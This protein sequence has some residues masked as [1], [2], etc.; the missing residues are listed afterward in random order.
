MWPWEHVAV[1]YIAYSLLSRTAVARRPGWA[2][3]VAVTVGALG[4]D[5]IDKPLAWGLGVFPDGYSLGHSVFFALPLAVVAVVVGGL[6]GRRAVGAAFGLGYLSHLPADVFYPMATG[7][8][9]AFGAVL[10]PYGPSSSPVTQGL[11]ENFWY[12]FRNYLDYLT[13][14]EAALFVTAEALLLLTALA[15]LWHDLGPRRRTAPPSEPNR[16]R[17]R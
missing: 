3:V 15:L 4:P 10:W 14:P 1:G 7:G 8:E 9:P 5:L 11:F 6:L 12:Y 13:S 17:N 16:N 2:E